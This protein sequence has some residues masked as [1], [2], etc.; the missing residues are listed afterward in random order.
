MPWIRVKGRRYYRQ[1]RRVGGR[2]VTTH[3]GAGPD[4]EAIAALD[5]TERVVR[6]KI[7][8]SGRAVTD[9]L[10]AGARTAL[11][12]DRVLADL[13]AVFATRFGLRLHR[14]C[15]WRQKRGFRMTPSD[16]PTAADERLAILHA[17]GEA[18]LLPLNAADVPEPDRA[19]LAAA[20]RGDRAALARAEKYLADARYTD[21]WGNPVHASRVWLVLQMSGN[22]AVAAAA[23]DRQM[24]AMEEGLGWSRAGLLERF[25]IT[26]VVH[27]WMGVCVLEARAAQ[28]DPAS[29]DRVL[30]ER[31]LTQ[32]ER[33]LQQSIRTLAYL[34]RVA[35][36][37]L[38][39]QV[40][41]AGGVASAE[42]PVAGRRAG[43]VPDRSGGPGEGV[44][45]PGVGAAGPPGTSSRAAA[46]D[47]SRPHDPVGRPAVA[48]DRDG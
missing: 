3:V 38:E 31:C 11:A 34:R 13:F 16:P 18:P 48:R 24:K 12:A 1:S 19:V 7:R 17:D 35:P 46:A 4:A 42:S 47:R 6:E 23:A 45:G 33:R 10:L 14:R 28:M 20:A 30:I 37:D 25:A 8:R 39:M 21:R 9:A 2:V 22:N 32:C 40:R 5:A 36:A 43:P 27:G 26:R 29:R 41:A 15:E 44:R